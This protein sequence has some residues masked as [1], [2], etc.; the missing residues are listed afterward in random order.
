MGRPI[1]V[2]KKSDRPWTRHNYVLWFGTCG[3][4]YL[5]VWANDLDSAVEIAAEWLLAHAPGHIM[6]HDDPELDVLR[7]EAA[8]E[9]QIDLEVALA[10]MRDG[11]GS[12]ICVIEEQAFADLTYTE[13]GYLTSY[14]WG[15]VAE[16]PTRA[17]LAD[18]YGTKCGSCGAG[19]AT[20]RP[21]C[22]RGARIEVSL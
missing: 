8:E 15:I 7:K 18:L 19:S 13:S 5:R 20:H 1:D 2:N 9:L 16:D 6:A 14:E 11:I 22:A 4:T 3:A 21:D 10:D 17:Q 12:E